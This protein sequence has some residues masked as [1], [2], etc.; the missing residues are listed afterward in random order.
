MYHFP[1]VFHN[2]PFLAFFTMC[3]F[4]PICVYVCPVCN[5]CLEYP[6]SGLLLYTAWM[7]SLY[8]MLKVCLVWP[9][10]LFGQ[11]KQLNW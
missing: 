2:F 1:S 5:M 10:Y 3:M 9:T 6:V 7:C 11:S 8:L 4:F